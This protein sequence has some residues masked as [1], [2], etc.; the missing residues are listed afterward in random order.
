M[1]VEIPDKETVQSFLPPYVPH[2]ILDPANPKNI[3]PV[4]L[5]DPRLNADGVLCHGYMELRYLLQESHLA[6][7]KVVLETGA[8]FG[9]IFGRDYGIY[10]SYR[11]D[12]AELLLVSMGS[13]ASEATDAIDALREEGYKI[14]IIH[15]RLYRPFPARTLAEAV[16]ATGCKGIA[17]M[18]KNVSY[19]YEGALASDLK[20]ALFDYEVKVFAHSYIAGLG[21][22]DV[23]AA[24][25]AAALKT[26]YA[27]LGKPEGQRQKVQEWINCKL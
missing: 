20:A 3:N 27:Y 24:E 9:T 10:D 12:D 16:R 11:T 5:A 8:E 17:V 19:G 4:T 1:P 22:R 18:E 7:E 15:V 2:T 14:G 26:S 13:L 6:T 23:K 21:G 25:I